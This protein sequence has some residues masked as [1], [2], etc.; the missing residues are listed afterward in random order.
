MVNVSILSDFKS[1]GVFVVC[2][3]SSRVFRNSVINL[4]GFIALLFFILYIFLSNLKLVNDYL[5][6]KMCTH[7]ILTEGAHSIA[8]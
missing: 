3:L 2:Y 6:S 7:S 5:K 4:E 1:Q 8:Y